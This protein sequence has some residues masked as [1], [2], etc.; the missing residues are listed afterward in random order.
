LLSETPGFSSNDQ[1]LRMTELAR[2][3]LATK[4]EMTGSDRPLMPE[5]IR[6]LLK[7]KFINPILGIYGAH[8]LLMEAPVNHQLL[9]EVV[10]NLRGLLGPHPDVEA[11]AMRVDGIPPPNTFDQPPMLRRS[12]SLLAEASVAR[13]SL[14]SA[15]LE[16]RSTGQTVPEG[17]WH[18]WRLPAATTVDTEA[19]PDALGLSDFEAALAENLNIMSQVRRAKPEPEQPGIGGLLDGVLSTVSRGLATTDSITDSIED[20]F[21]DVFAGRAPA[22][23][24]I[25]LD[26]DDSKMRELATRFGVPS[27]QLKRTL[28]SLEDKL[29][30]SSWAPNLKVVLK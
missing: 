12:W 10:G 27:M 8:L 30:R 20:R 26:L 2:V 13:P 3:S 4:R 6:T 18:I 7:E 23:Q 29:T 15:A 17:P 24:D 16:A 5:E 22:P 1:M 9:A 21:R 14:L 11:I 28:T 19:D 25:E